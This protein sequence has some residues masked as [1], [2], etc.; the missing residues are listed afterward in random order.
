MTSITLNQLPINQDAVISS[1]HC[2]EEIR[3]RLLDLGLVYQ[4]KIT[5]ILLS[6]SRWFNCL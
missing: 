1:L 4:T 6:P 5:P 2:D 3:R